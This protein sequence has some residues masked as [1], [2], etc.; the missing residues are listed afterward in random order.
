MAQKKDVAKEPDS[1][2]DIEATTGN[3]KGIYFGEQA[4]KY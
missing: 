1:D 2:V 3:Y 4:E